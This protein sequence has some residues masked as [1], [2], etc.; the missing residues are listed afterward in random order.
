MI[1]Y[2][3]E[4]PNAK[5]ELLDVELLLELVN[6]SACVNK[7]LLAGE[8][9]MTLRADINAKIAFCG[10]CNE[11]FAAS[12][13]NSNFVIFRMEIFFHEFPSLSFEN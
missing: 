1:D 12:A 11:S 9:R 10:F 8:E 2:R 7:L 5:T 6:S 13:L 4:L 3:H